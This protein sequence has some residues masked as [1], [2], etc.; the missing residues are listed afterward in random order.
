MNICKY[1]PALH[2][3]STKR[4][5]CLFAVTLF[6]TC[7]AA[8][9]AY[10]QAT[11][12]DVWVDSSNVNEDGDGAVVVGRGVTEADYTDPE[13]VEVE[14]T[15]TSPSGRTATSSAIG[16]ISAQADAGL[17]FD[18]N[19]LG[20]Y[21]AV[22]LHYFV[23][24]NDYEPPV[25]GYHWYDNPYPYDPYPSLYCPRMPI[26]RIVLFPVGVSYLKMQKIATT[27]APVQGGFVYT[28]KRVEPCDVTCRNMLQHTTN[29][30]RGECAGF[31]IPY[32]PF[33]CLIFTKIIS[34]TTC[35]CYDTNNN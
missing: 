2:R 10:G 3:N 35:V 18:W 29:I 6:L 7:V 15:L 1:I 30:D 34:N 21:S 16:E 11:F 32:G 28:Y 14:T 4:L 33:G 17:L 25:W 23:C 5:F 20:N 31:V 9:A 19:D 22:S 8:P 27:P 12:S 24:L 26:R 13:A